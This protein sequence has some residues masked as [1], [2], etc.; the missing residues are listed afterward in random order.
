MDTLERK[1]YARV[2][3]PSSFRLLSIYRYARCIVEWILGWECEMEESIHVS[4][5]INIHF[6]TGVRYNKYSRHTTLIWLVCASLILSF[7]FHCFE[8]FFRFFLFIGQ[9]IKTNVNYRICKEMEVII[10]SFSCFLCSL[11]SV[12]ILKMSSINLIDTNSWIILFYS[13]LLPQ[14]SCVHIY[15]M[16]SFRRRDI[17]LLMHDFFM[18]NNLTHRE[19]QEWQILC[20]WCC[21]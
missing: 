17:R 12:M 11:W 5:I 19:Q 10:H 18:I 14:F 20:R 16:R 3:T 4:I 15:A 2:I 8:G 1:L 6:R 9:L 21:L 13:Q 7:L